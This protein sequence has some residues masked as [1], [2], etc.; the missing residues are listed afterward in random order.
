[1]ETLISP[2]QFRTLVIREPF[3]RESCIRLTDLV[4]DGIFSR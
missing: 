3:D 2:L 4:L 1:M